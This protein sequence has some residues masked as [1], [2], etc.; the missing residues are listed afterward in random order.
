MANNINQLI[1]K[2]AMDAYHAGKPCDIITGIVTETKPL[3]IKISDKVILDVLDDDFLEI[4]QTASEAGL[5]KGDKAAL[6][7]A[8]GGQKYLVIDKVV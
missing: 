2:I 4:T 6:I 7:R 3:R 5:E 8:D 1:K